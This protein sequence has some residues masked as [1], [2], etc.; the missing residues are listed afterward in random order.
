MYETINKVK[1]FSLKLQFIENKY[2]L[3]LDISS[4]LYDLVLTHDF[5]VI[6]TEKEYFNYEFSQ[7]FWY[8][9]GRPIKPYHRIRT[10]KI[11]KESPLVLEVII[12]SLGGIWVL[13]QIIDKVQNWPLNREKL[14]LEVEK[15]RC[16][17]QILRNELLI[18]HENLEL[19]AESRRAMREVKNLIERLNR[20]PLILQAIDTNI[21]KLENK[22][23]E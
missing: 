1:Y 9:Q 21:V 19:L 20:S 8:R 22:G 5:S 11:I 14:K 16:E 23:D 12:A 13:L 17:Q 3:L 15:L 4:L 2:P 6:I 7:Y 18:K 10:A